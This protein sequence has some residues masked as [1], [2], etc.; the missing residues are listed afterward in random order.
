MIKNYLL[1]VKKIFHLLENKELKD[2]KLLFFLLFIGGFAE[3][4]SIGILFL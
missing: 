3:T 1:E 2:L 4:L